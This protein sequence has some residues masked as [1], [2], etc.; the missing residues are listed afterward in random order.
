MDG[1]TLERHQSAA[2]KRRSSVLAGG[3]VPRLGFGSG[4]GGGR[5]MVARGTFGGT[6]A[7]AIKG[8]KMN[9]GLGIG[10]GGGAVVMGNAVVKSAIVADGTSSAGKGGRTASLHRGSRSKRKR[11]PPGYENNWRGRLPHPLPFALHQVE[12]VLRSHALT[13]FIVVLT[14]TDLFLEDIK[15]VLFSPSQDRVFGIMSLLVF[16]VFSMEVMLNSIVTPGYFLSVF[17]FL[18]AVSSVSLLPDVPWIWLPLVGLRTG[19]S[20]VTDGGQ[21]HDT[22]FEL[23]RITRVSRTEAHMLR[24]MR[25]VKLLRLGRVAKLFEVCQRKVE[26]RSRDKKREATRAKFGSDVLESSEYAEPTALGSHLAERTTRKVVA[27][28]LRYVT[29]NTQQRHARASKPCDMATVAYRV[30]PFSAFLC[31]F[32]CSMF[33]FFPAFQHV[34]HHALVGARNFRLEHGV[35]GAACAQAGE[36]VGTFLKRV[37]GAGPGHG[38]VDGARPTHG[39]Q[40]RLRHAHPLA[41]AGRLLQLARTTTPFRGQVRRAISSAEPILRGQLDRSG[42]GSPD[43]RRLAGRHRPNGRRNAL[44]DKFLQQDA[45]VR[46]R[47]GPMVRQ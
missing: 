34:D 3:M 13:L 19:D 18:D 38:G 24:V 8:G 36:L 32:V 17:F 46:A 7:L 47:Q 43:H 45:V 6:N 39:Q 29:D 10:I 40:Y 16:C 5:G 22:A 21:D 42:P 14:F 15:T 26:E 25:F 20:G 33:F 23:E 1:A 12:R 41:L 28:V 9:V 4:F 44:V 27:L 11:V 35:R 30:F 31:A 2:M 37:R